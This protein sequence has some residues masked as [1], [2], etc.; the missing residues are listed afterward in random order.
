MLIEAAVS[1]DRN[2]FKKEVEMILKSKDLII[3]I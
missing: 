2:L 3:E 1:G